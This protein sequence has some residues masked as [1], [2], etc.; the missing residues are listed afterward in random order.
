M[1]ITDLNLSDDYVRKNMPLNMTNDMARKN[2]PL[3]IKRLPANVWYV[4][5][6]NE[7]RYNSTLLHRSLAS[8]EWLRVGDRIQLE[9]SPARTLR[10]LLNSEDMNIQFTNVPDDIYVIVELKGSTMAV[11]AISTQ[12]PSS[13][14]R[15][16]SLRLQDSLEFGVDLKDSMLESM[17]EVQSYEFSEF[18]GKNIVLS[19]ENRCATRISS[20]QQG[21]VY[22]TKPLQK[23]ESVT[24]SL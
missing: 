5:G 16:C 15:P 9:L 10:I 7:V 13:P 2:I 24:V 8:L 12:S 22:M 1:G 20:Y 19:D 23:G 21:L 18:H 17:S 4:S 11:E 3:S 6:G 14:L